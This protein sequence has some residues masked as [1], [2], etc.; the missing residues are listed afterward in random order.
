MVLV[1]AQNGDTW[2]LDEEEWLPM[3]FERYPLRI[4]VK[5]KE[6]FDQL[7]IYARE[8]QSMMN[9]TAS[10]EEEEEEEARFDEEF[11]KRYN[12]Y[13]LQHIGHIASVSIDSIFRLQVTLVG[14]K[15]SKMTLSFRRVLGC[16]P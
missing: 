9:Q 2:E 5:N 11:I 10:V 6:A 16:W 1:Q 13:S 3:L 14:T 12:D 4:P 7:V 15:I 8:R